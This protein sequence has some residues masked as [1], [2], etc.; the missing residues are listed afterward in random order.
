MSSISYK[1]DKLLE[2]KKL[3]KTKFAKLINVNRDTVYNLSDETIKVST[4][5]KISEILDT[6]IEYFLEKTPQKTA[7]VSEPAV[8]YEP[9]KE[10]CETLKRMNEF[11]MAQVEA[12]RISIK[13]LHRSI[14]QLSKLHA[15]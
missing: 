10:D 14:E 5:L 3:S 4:L 7:K 15:H 8:K 1:I 9:K 13:V 6:P 12:D 2:V 11:L